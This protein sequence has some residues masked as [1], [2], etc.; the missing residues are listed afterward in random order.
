MV[1]VCRMLVFHRTWSRSRCSGCG[2]TTVALADSPR[3][4]ITNPAS[5]RA[6][7]LDWPSC[8]TTVGGTPPCTSAPGSVWGS[9]VEFGTAVGSGVGVVACS[10]VSVAVDGG[11]GVAADGGGNSVSAAGLDVHAWRFHVD[12]S[13]SLLVQ[14]ARRPQMRQARVS[15][16]QH[17]SL[18][19]RPQLGPRSS[20]CTSPATDV[21]QAH[22]G[23]FAAQTPGLFRRCASVMSMVVCRRWRLSWV[24]TARLS[25]V[26]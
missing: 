8:S 7:A 14:S 13:V 9:V 24:V 12:R 22:V 25:S 4:R 16:P 11:V 19:V 10:G 23:R 2:R 3:T 17:S 26:P 20:C 1:L 15:L 18:A 5:G 21:R 6:R